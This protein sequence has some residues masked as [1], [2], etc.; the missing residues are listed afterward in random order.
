MAKIVEFLKEP[1]DPNCA[2]F[3]DK[4]GTLRR[5]EPLKR[6]VVSD[7]IAASM[8]A[9]GEAQ[10]VGEAPEPEGLSEA[11]RIRRMTPDMRPRVWP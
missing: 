5:A 1:E 3:R 10:I 9:K 11:E 8:V 7:C 2:F 4:S 6:I